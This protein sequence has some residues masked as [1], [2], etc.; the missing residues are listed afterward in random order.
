M[1]APT[2]ITFFSTLT[3]MVA[4]GVK[5]ITIR[6]ESESH[7]QP[8]SRVAVH[9]L[10]TD[11]YVCDIVIDSVT[12]LA[13]EDIN[14]RHAEQEGMSLTDLKALILQIYPERPPLFVIDFHLA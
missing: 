4:A 8:G 5:T 10:E 12:P 1:T 2:K 9:Q 7:Y 6:D 11:D 13:F 3:P 14:A